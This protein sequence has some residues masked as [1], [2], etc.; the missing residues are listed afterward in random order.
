MPCPD[1]VGA[2]GAV[3]LDLLHHYLPD[4]AWQNDIADA[5]TV[6]LHAIA[7]GRLSRQPVQIRR[8]LGAAVEHLIESA[9]GDHV[10]QGQLQLLMKLLGVVLH[11]VEGAERIGDAILRHQRDAHFDAVGGQDALAGDDVA[12]LAETDLGHIH[13]IAKPEGVAPRLQHAL[14]FALAVQQ[15]ALV[16]VDGDLFAKAKTGPFHGGKHRRSP[17]RVSNTG[18]FGCPRLTAGEPGL[19]PSLFGTPWRPERRRWVSPRPQAHF[20]R[21]SEDGKHLSS[22]AWNESLLRQQQ[23]LEIAPDAER[24]SRT[25]VRRGCQPYFTCH[26]GMRQPGSAAFGPSRKRRAE[27]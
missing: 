17:L 18:L 23:G 7:L 6:Q 14:Q 13:R 4:L 16:L 9:A 22:P 8:D 27:N 19:T 24:T 26:R 5:H 21:P 20:R 15:A 11:R 2:A 12:H 3:G 25:G 1:E 10:S